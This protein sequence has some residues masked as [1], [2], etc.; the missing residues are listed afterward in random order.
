MEFR[1]PGS[2]YIVNGH[3]EYLYVST[4]EKWYR[5]VVGRWYE[6]SKPKLINV[7]KVVSVVP[8]SV[9]G[10]LQVADRISGDQL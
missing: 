8:I 6:C 2:C 4:T 9:Y 10:L 1:V 5:R 3:R 7:L